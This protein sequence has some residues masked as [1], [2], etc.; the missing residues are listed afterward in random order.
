[1]QSFYDRA[2]RGWPAIGILLIRVAAAVTIGYRAPPAHAAELAAA[3]LLFAGMWTPAAAAVI[4]AFECWRTVFHAGG[5][6]SLLLTAMT[7]A[8]ALIG[9]GTWSLDARI[10]GWRRID[11]P[12]PQSEGSALRSDE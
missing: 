10:V 8:V 7:L 12:A 9:A 4:A 6:T 5:W 3:L 1:M 11:I 2:L